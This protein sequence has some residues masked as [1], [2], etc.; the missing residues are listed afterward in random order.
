MLNFLRDRLL[1]VICIFL[2]FGCSTPPEQ[3]EGEKEESSSSALKIFDYVPELPKD[4]IQM[5]SIILGSTGFDAFRIEVDSARNWK[6]LEAQYGKSRVYE[7][8]AAMA[9]IRLGVEAYVQSF[10]DSGVERSNIHFLVSSSAKENDKVQVVIRILSEL[11]YEPNEISEQFEARCA[12]YA[13]VP[14]EYRNSAFVVDIGSGNTK[15]SWLEGDELQMKITYGSKYHLDNV[16]DSTAYHGAQEASTRIPRDCAEY[17][18]VIGGAPFQ[19]AKGIRIME[20][21]Y[22]VLKD[23][24]LYPEVT[25]QQVRNGL[26]LYEGIKSS[27]K[28]EQ[29]I[30]DWDANFAIGYLLS[31][32]P[33]S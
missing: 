18:F 22:T 9:D 17:A 14:K 13:A 15:V 3:K 33:G 12:F 28:C 10:L 8:E 24:E 4:G 21:R 23:P 6:L 25:D 20:E 32:K 2:F 30:F 27:T 19:L 11:G 16:P 1:F 7:N 31:L 5:G 26:K 29:F